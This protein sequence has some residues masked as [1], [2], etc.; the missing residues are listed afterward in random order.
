MSAQASKT[1]ARTHFALEEDEGSCAVI[2]E[3]LWNDIDFLRDG[4][5][6][7]EPGK[8]ISIL[9]HSRSGLSILLRI[10]SGFAE[11]MIVSERTLSQHVWSITYCPQSKCSA[12]LAKYYFSTV[13]HL[14]PGLVFW[15]RLRG[16]EGALLVSVKTRTGHEHTK[17][18]T[19]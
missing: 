14:F 9:H 19:N 7:E 5:V 10:S 16:K 2:L 4:S 15:Q 11:S 13:V 12:Y 8:K 17:V 3:Q 6:T 18:F 1:H